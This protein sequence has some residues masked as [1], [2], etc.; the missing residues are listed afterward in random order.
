MMEASGLTDRSIGG[1]SANVARYEKFLDDVLKRELRG[2]EEEMQK[3][4]RSIEEVK[5]L[6]RT[7]QFLHSSKMSD[8]DSMINLGCETLMEAYVPEAS[9][10][11]VDVGFGF[12]LE[13]DRPEAIKF[14]D[15]KEKYLNGCYSHWSDKSAKTKANIKLFMEALSALLGADVFSLD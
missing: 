15:K 1:P 14:L 11:Y 10:V 3:V 2:I 12:F 13:F 5:T 4:E 8:F 7:L 6:Q 9:T